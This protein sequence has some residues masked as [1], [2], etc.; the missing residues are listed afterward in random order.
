MTV[1]QRASDLL[2]ESP[3]SRFPT[4]DLPASPPPEVLAAVDAAWERARELFTAGLN[5]HFVVDRGVR[6]ELRTARGEVAA[7]Y[8]AGQAL[9]FACGDPVLR[10]ARFDSALMA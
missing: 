2:K 8:S 4:D 3:M 10:G 5:L 6:A 9:A 7:R 1:V